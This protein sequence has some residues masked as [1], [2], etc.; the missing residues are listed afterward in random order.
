LRLAILLSCMFLVIGCGNREPAA[1]E[2]SAPVA[3]K[4]TEQP[5][6]ETTDKPKWSYSGET[7]PEAWG[8]LSP[9]YA[10]CDSGRAQSP[11]DIRGEIVDAAADLSFD[12][13]AI[14][15]RIIDN[16][17]TIQVNT[18]G[19]SI[20]TGGKTYELLQM[21][22][23][24]RSEHFVEGKDF[25]MVV[26]LVHADDAG[27][28]AVVGVFFEEGEAHPVIDAIWNNL[29]EEQGVETT[30]TDVNLDLPSLLPVDQ[31]YFTY[32]G[33]LTTP[34]CGEG[35]AWHVMATP[36]EM[37]REQID[38][39]AALYPDNRRPVQP[40]HDREIRLHR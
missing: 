1:P 3:E 19:S 37:S 23:H 4:T 34:A 14:P 24:H 20:T 25:D 35:V 26:H 12:Y 39:F 2:S 36:I 15:A 31:S 10:L 21:H 7:G 28:L 5:P 32:P 22:F 6:K 9:E 18:G 11:I 16:G 29:P 13:G 30:L 27:N 38:A 33:S 40:L 8:S 17:H